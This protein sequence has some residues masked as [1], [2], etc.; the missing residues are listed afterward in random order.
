MKRFSLVMVAALAACEATTTSSDGG[1][2]VS[3]GARVYSVNQDVFEVTARPGN[4]INQFW[5]GAGEYASRVLGAPAN[6]RIYVVGE[7]GPGTV[8]ESPNAMQFSLL[9]PGQASGATGRQSTWGPDLGEDEFVGDARYR[10]VRRV[11]FFSN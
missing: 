1:F 6:A 10:C 8:V 9:P 2:V 4:E 11:D 7:A 3:N 5:C